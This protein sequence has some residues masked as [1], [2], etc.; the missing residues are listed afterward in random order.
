METINEKNI[1]TMGTSESKTM[2]SMLKPKDIIFVLD[3]SGSMCSMGSEPQDSVNRTIADQKA[4]NIPGTKFTLIK[5]NSRVNIVYDDLPLEDVPKFEGYAPAEM[6][7][8]YD[9][10]GTAI[11]NK[12]SK[13][14]GNYDDVICGILTDGMENCSKDYVLKSGTR[15]NA[16]RTMIKEMETK[17]S[18]Q[19]VYA[20]ANQDAFAVGA[21]MGMA[22]CCDYTPT[23]FGLQ[24]MTREISGGIGRMRSGESATVDIFSAVSA[25]RMNTQPDSPRPDSP[26]TPTSGSQMVRATAGGAF[27]SPSPPQL[28]RARR[29]RDGFGRGA[30]ASPPPPLRIPK[31]DE[32]GEEMVEEVSDANFENLITLKRS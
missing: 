30:F 5:F 11:D 1:E 20:A 17:H 19:F 6:T 12:K 26:R 14:E 8:L 7:A 15:K 18:W 29:M 10:I 23:Q 28:K 13:G 27:G 2:E 32:D 22:T 4:L 31:D 16:I 9:A 25:P 3:E 24:N 21:T